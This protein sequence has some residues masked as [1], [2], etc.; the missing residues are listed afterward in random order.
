M[1]LGSSDKWGVYHSLSLALPTTF[2][3]NNNNNNNNKSPLFEIYYS[4]WYHKVDL[5]KLCG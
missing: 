4:N 3:N 1:G 5:T 2:N